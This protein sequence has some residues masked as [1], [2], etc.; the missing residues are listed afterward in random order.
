MLAALLFVITL[1]LYAP[2]YHADFV[3][4]DDPMYVT[5]NDWVQQ[6]LSWPTFQKAWTERVAGNWHP[7]TM[8]SH[9]T[10]VTFFGLDP[11]GHHATS[12]LLHAL[13]TVILFGIFRALFGGLFRPALAAALFALHP[14]SIDTAVWIA[15]RKN[16]LS[17]FFWLSATWLYIRFVHRSSVA[18]ML[19]TIGLFLI[20]LMTKPMLVTFPVTLLMLDLWPLRRVRGFSRDDW[21]VWNR[22]IQEKTVL[23]MLTLLFSTFTLVTQ[24]PSGYEHTPDPQPLWA[25]A[26][27]SLQHY[28]MYLEKFFWPTGFSV[29][30]PRLELPPDLGAVAMAGALL[31]VITA[32]VQLLVRRAP[33]LAF[34][35]FWFVGTMFPVIGIIGIGQ[36]SIT[37]RYMYI[38]MIGLII[39]VVWGFP[40]WSHRGLR[41]TFSLL[42]V[43]I[44]IGCGWA[45]RAALPY[46]QNSEVLFRRAVEVTEGN[47]IMLS[48]LG[49]QLMLQ[50][51]TEEGMELFQQALAINP[52]HVK[53]LNNFGFGLSTQG[54]DDDAIG[55]FEQAL[56]EDSAYGIARIN[57][58]RS[59]MKQAR[60]REALE[61]Y[62]ILI[63]FEPDSVE[64]REGRRIARQQLGI[65]ASWLPP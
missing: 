1:W 32:A 53:S 14:F 30:Y 47:Y 6:G 38:P 41:L 56:R 23:F 2:A 44:V 17:S 39:A 51:R 16:V 33:A 64:V 34:G 8:L 13:N 3:D 55:Y 63:T 25:K 29:F 52:S 40:S 9:L 4:Y 37:D 22:L 27:F 21:L 5:E 62:D 11:R 45:T 20:G 24:F 48:N 7:I 15:E 60:Y 26:L 43:G 12:L 36:H 46:W 61:H 28:Q 35:W 65:P 19:G 58:A 49:R 18:A 31:L 10:D 57:L 42:G 54:R 50:G 59:L